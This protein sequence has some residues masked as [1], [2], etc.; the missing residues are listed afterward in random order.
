VALLLNPEDPQDVPRAIELIQAL[1]DLRNL[2]IDLD[3]VESKTLIAIKLM[4]HLFNCLIQPYIDPT[5]SLTQQIKYLSKFQHVA[6]VLYRKNSTTFFP[7]QLYG[8]TS[9]MIKSTVFYVRKQQLWDPT[10]GVFLTLTGD[11]QLETQFGRVHMQGAHDANCDM[12]S[13]ADRICA[14]MDLNRVFTRH[15]SWD[16]G[17][18]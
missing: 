15:P 9:V 18:R 3:P 2:D 8:D 6:M 10:C 7:G 17:H 13:L 5:L 16:Q 12:K 11:D 1:A 4:G 14:A